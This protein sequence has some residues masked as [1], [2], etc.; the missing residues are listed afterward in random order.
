MRIPE[1]KHRQPTLRRNEAVDDDEVIRYSERQPKNKEKVAY[2]EFRPERH[3]QELRKQRVKGAEN[4]LSHTPAD[5]TP[6]LTTS[7]NQRQKRKEK[8][9]P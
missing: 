3:E 2:D 5:N 1:T 9:K 6:V 7:Q 8:Q 4:F